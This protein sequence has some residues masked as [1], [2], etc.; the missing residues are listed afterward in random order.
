M[1]KRI[2][3]ICTALVLASACDDAELHEDQ[4]IDAVDGDKL[5][6]EPDAVDEDDQDAEPGEEVAAEEDRV[7]P[8]EAAE[9]PLCC[10]AHCGGTGIY[11]RFW[12][13]PSDCNHHAWNFCLSTYGTNL[14]NAEW[15]PCP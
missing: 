1:F 6:A 3:L 9:G 8:S 7:A 2:M 10:Y 5:G 15:M 4:A 11:Q 14:I 13:P 12:D